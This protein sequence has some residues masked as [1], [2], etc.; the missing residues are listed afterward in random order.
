MRSATRTA[1]LSCTT[2]STMTVNSSPP[3]RTTLSVGR[4]IDFRRKLA[5]CNSS[6]PAAC[7]SV[8]LTSLKPSRSTKRRPSIVPVLFARSSAAGRKLTSQWRFGRPVSSSWF[9]RRNSSHSCAFAALMS[10]TV[11][12]SPVPARTNLLWTQS[13]LTGLSGAICHSSS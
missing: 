11:T 9:A 3:K 4:R 6:S 10:C 2:G 7:P 5:A 13:I 12:A 8:S 1:S